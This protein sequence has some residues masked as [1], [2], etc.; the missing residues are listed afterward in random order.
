MSRPVPE[1]DDE[2]AGIVRAFV[3]HMADFRSVSPEGVGLVG[4]LDSARAYVRDQ[5]E[6]AACLILVLLSHLPGFPRPVQAEEDDD[7]Q[8]T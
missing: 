7:E 5:P 6:A 1:L 3:K 4:G 8:A 2:E